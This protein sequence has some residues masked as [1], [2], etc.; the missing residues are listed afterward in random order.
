[1]NAS[2]YYIF[3]YNK[4][5]TWYNQLWGNRGWFFTDP[6]ATANSSVLC[7]SL[8]VPMVLTTPLGLALALARIAVYRR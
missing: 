6:F 4:A 3:T 1:L 2:P 8:R 7:G 5:V